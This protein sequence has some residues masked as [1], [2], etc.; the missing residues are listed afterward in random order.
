MRSLVLPL[1]LAAAPLAAAP[2]N[3]PVPKVVQAAGEHRGD[4]ELQS[5]R[6]QLASAV[7]VANLKLTAEQKDALQSV[8][9]EARK[10][11]EEMKIDKKLDALRADRKVALKAAIDEVH[12]KGSLSEKTK[13]SLKDGG[14]EAVEELGDVREKMKSFR[15]SVIGILTPE[16]LDRMKELRAQRVKKMEAA[17][18]KAGMK[19][20]KGAGKQRLMRLLLSDEF[21]AE[22][23]R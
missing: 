12:S 1:L 22:L 2:K 6:R 21:A 14:R 8:L 18:M 20:G 17:G 5:L 11:R 7:L 23:E 10:T 3:A 4:P 9:A 16:Q 15:Q 19:A 13:E